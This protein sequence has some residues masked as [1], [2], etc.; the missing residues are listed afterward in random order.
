MEYNGCVATRVTEGS[1]R[2]LR[3]LTVAVYEAFTC[4]EDCRSN[5]GGGGVSAVADAVCLL[6][7]S[8][9]HVS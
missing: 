2:P 3:R 8:T 9:G 5:E 1:S 7:E 6:A 4:T